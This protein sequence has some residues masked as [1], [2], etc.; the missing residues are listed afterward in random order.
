MC[1]AAAK[2]FNKKRH[3]DRAGFAL[4]EAHRVCSSTMTLSRIA[5]VSHVF[6]NNADHGD[7]PRD[8]TASASAP[9]PP[10]LSA[11]VVRRF[12]A[13][14]DEV[15]DTLMQDPHL[16]R[17]ACRAD[18]IALL[19]ATSEHVDGP[20]DSGESP[21]MYLLLEEQQKAAA[22]LGHAQGSGHVPAF[23]RV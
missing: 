16:D 14:I 15:T 3:I 2:N 6:S 10:A 23:L 20:S 7:D 22:V 11:E 21:L 1:P 17:R 12:H 8:G 18:A 19:I 4:G 5:P 9:T 13:L